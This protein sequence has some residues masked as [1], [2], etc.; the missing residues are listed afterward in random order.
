MLVFPEDLGGHEHH[1][2]ASVWK[3]REFQVLEC[4]HDARRGAGFLCQLAHTEQKR[5]LGILSQR[6]IRIFA[7]DGPSL[8]LVKTNFAMSVHFFEIVDVLLSTHLWLDKILTNFSAHLFLLP[9]GHYFGNV[10]GR[11]K[12]KRNSPLGMGSVPIISLHRRKALPLRPSLA[13]GVD[14][15]QSLFSLWK[16]RSLNRESLRQWA[17]A[18]EAN[19]YIGS[20]GKILF[21][22]LCRCLLRCSARSGHWILGLCSSRTQLLGHFLRLCCPQRLRVFYRATLVL[23]FQC[24]H[25]QGHPEL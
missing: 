5:P 19:T 22:L 7:W 20:I 2:P 23:V 12:L 4:D 6:F 24:V 17:E 15:R 13:S 10:F 25:V 9:L 11:L 3:L 8:S 16:S 18:K 14:S 21:R 1:G